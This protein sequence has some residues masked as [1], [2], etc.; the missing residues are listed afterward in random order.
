MEERKKYALLCRDIEILQDPM[1]AAIENLLRSNLQYFES[2]V[3]SS[4]E[5]KVF[6]HNDLLNHGYK[7]IEIF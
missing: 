5:E 3:F 2:Y 7:I 1:I 6:T 4:E